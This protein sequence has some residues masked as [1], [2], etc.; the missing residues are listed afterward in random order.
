MKKWTLLL[1]SIF[2]AASILSA[3]SGTNQGEQEL[4][5]EDNALQQEADAN[6][7]QPVD[8][9]QSEGQGASLNDPPVAEP[10]PEE[11]SEEGNTAVEDDSTETAAIPFTVA[12]LD[13]NM[14]IGMTKEEV[15]ALIGDDYAEITMAMDNAEGWR[16][17]IG[18]VDG[19]SFDDV[20]D[21]VDLEGIKQGD[22][23]LQIFIQ[24][25]SEGQVNGYSAYQ[26]DEDGSISVYQWLENGELKTD[27]IL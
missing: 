27:T 6:T 3:C 2:A 13:A 11:H 4:R 10:L 8:P 24:F 22:V 17:D 21:S 9:N 19:Y 12:Q 14:A 23:A 26:A 5:E 16:Y 15:A 20:L 18:A 1:A 7:E 25:D